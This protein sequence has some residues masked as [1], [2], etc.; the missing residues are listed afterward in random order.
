MLSNSSTLIDS[1]SFTNDLTRYLHVRIL[2]LRPLLLEL[3]D[4]EHALH[5]VSQDSSL[6]NTIIQR[7]MLTNISNICVSTAQRQIDHILV[8]VTGGGSEIHAWWY[9][10]YCKHQNANAGN[11][12][13][14]TSIY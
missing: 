14:K 8:N 6:L 5:D 3:F 12:C 4:K 10:V 2:L 11:F 9:N 7:T 1:T 13:A